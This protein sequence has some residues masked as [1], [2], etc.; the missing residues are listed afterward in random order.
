MNYQS[1][2]INWF[3]TCLAGGGYKRLFFINIRL[4]CRHVKALFQF[5]KFWA[6][7]GFDVLEWCFSSLQ[8]TQHQ[9]H[10]ESHYLVS[11]VLPVLSLMKNEW[12]TWS[13]YIKLRDHRWPFNQR[14]PDGLFCIW[15]DIIFL[16]P[17]ETILQ[18]LATR[19][20][21]YI[22]DKGW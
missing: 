3:C 8:S 15:L 21:P 2:C 12:S 22:Y 11:F 18:I 10:V 6:G 9:P 4:R 1:N 7:V 20:H 19:L 13:W 17:L 14:N 16:N 5:Q